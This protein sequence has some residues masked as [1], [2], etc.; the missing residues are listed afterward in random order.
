M[1]I[2]NKSKTFFLPNKQL[3]LLL[4]GAQSKQI[5]GFSL[6]SREL[7]LLAEF[8]CR[9]SRHSFGV[10]Q[11]NEEEVMVVGGIRDG[12]VTAECLVL[13]VE[14]G[15][16]RPLARLHYPAKG[17]FLCR[18]NPQKVYKFGGLNDEKEFI[19]EIEEYDEFQFRWKVVPFLQPH[20]S[21]YVFAQNSVA[22][23]INPLQ[24]FIFGGYFQDS[25]F[26]A[27]TA[28]ITLYD[29]TQ[30]GMVLDLVENAPLNLKVKS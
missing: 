7:R 5:F 24:I 2:P 16:I 12:L 29:D 22:L 1:Q 27:K 6:L 8:D 23:L 11:K 26:N 13:N 18:V 28:M 30:D 20:K 3:V 19:Q 4:G 10:I 15:L 25:K 21:Q 17:C 9:M 14:T